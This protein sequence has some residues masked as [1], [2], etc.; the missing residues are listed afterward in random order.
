MEIKEEAIVTI[1]RAWY[2][3][4]H[5]QEEIKDMVKLWRIVKEVMDHGLG[6]VEISIEDGEIKQNGITQSKRI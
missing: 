3:D 6:R 4:I 5:T 2:P 1:V